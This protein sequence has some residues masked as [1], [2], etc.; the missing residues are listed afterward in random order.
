MLKFI[1]SKV[2]TIRLNVKNKK[3]KIKNLI[4]ISKPNLFQVKQNFHQV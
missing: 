4:F 3:K 1:F 2:A